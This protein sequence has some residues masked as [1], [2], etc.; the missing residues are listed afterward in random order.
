[1]MTKSPSKKQV[2]IPMSIGNRNKFIES[3]SS[4]INNL[5][6]A[7]K[8]IKLDVMAD[9]TCSDQAGITIVMNKVTALLD[10][11][12]IE[13]YVKQANQID[14]ENIKTSQL[15]Q[16]KFYLKI[17]GILYLLEYTNT[18]I[19]A[20]IVETIIKSNHIFNNI[21]VI[22][23]LSDMQSLNASFFI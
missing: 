10:L 8:N 14:S 22:S 11:Q 18:T 9:F 19:L 5:N 15:P 1:M 7:L 20:D 17:I 16:S 13:K 21:A 23:K 12:M 2:I 3:L 4:H 6:R